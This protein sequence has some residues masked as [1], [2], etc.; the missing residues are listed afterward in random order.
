MP[1]DRSGLVRPL[2]LLIMPNRPTSTSRRVRA[3]HHIRASAIVLIVVYVP[4]IA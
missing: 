3:Q 4:P 1:S 2:P